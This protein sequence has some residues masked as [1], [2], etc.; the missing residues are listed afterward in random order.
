MII[1][2]KLL[3]QHLFNS[4]SNQRRRCYADVHSAYEIGNVIRNA[5]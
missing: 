5:D 3:L 4:S 1:R 2:F